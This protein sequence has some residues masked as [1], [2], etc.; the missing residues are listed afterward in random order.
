MP[1]LEQTHSIFEYLD[2]FLDQQ[3]SYQ[4]LCWILYH[5]QVK[6]LNFFL[7]YYESS[8]EVYSVNGNVIDPSS[9]YA[10][11]NT[12]TDNWVDDLKIDFNIRK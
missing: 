5:I 12:E 2:L 9:D 3:L 1:V 6:V 4:S 10:V 7:M 11:S 8:H